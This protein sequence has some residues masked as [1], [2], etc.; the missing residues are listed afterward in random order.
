MENKPTRPVWAEIDLGLLKDN[1][2]KLK[3]NV[4]RK[5]LIMA[6][7]KA[8]AYGHGV[9]E[10]AK[11]LVTLG[12]D[13]LA[14]AIPEE[15]AELRQA[16]VEVPIQVLGEIFPEQYPVVLDNDLIQT[17]ASEATLVELN[18]AAREAKKKLKIHVKI[19]TGMGRLGLLAEDAVPFIKKAANCPFLELEGLLTHF[20][21]A[22]E[23]D[24][25]YTKMQ[26]NKFLQVLNRLEK[27][28][29]Q[30]PIKHVANSAAIIDQQELALDMVRPGIMLFGM[31]PSVEVGKEYGLKPI[32]N[33]KA[34]ISHLKK[35]PPDHGVSYSTI[36]FTEKEERIAII[37]VGYADGY[38]RLLS[39]KGEVLIN[40]RR[41]PIRGR[42][43]M[44]RFMVSVDHLPEAKVGDEVVLIGR[45]GNEEI[46]VVEMADWANTINYDIT[47]GITK[48]VPR[49][50]K[51]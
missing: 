41:A 18:E 24:K 42:I 14:V 19:D 30:I 20:A 4:P 22:D 13:R 48:R 38:N 43:C 17:V 23:K 15:G 2:L 47:C 10:V 36:Y 28:G 9:L 5:T 45:Q 35:L 16:G 1:F 25:S 46:S 11:T 26:W 12:V 3:E 34:R 40:G 27:E 33:W 6:V 8:D 31:Q 32:L 29:I 21:R 7:V 51:K 44:D 39:N 49:V 50:Y 37:P